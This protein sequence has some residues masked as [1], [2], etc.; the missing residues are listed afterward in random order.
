[1][2]GV[3]KGEWGKLLKPSS[4]ALPIST[5]CSLLGFP[6]KNKIIHKAEAVC[7]L[8]TFGRIAWK[9]NFDSTAD[10]LLQQAAMLHLPSSTL[11][12]SRTKL[13]QWIKRD[14]S[15]YKQLQCKHRPQ[16]LILVPSALLLR[17]GCLG[18]RGGKWFYIGCG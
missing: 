6:F 2:L 3:D 16:R 9:M 17:K 7:H 8:K 15:Q 13:Q 5:A 4:Y 14:L 18:K 12:S 10:A 1:L 11:L